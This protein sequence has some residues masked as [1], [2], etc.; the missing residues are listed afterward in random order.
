MFATLHNLV[1]TSD[2]PFKT[3][4]GISSKR[5]AELRR[6]TAYEQLRAYELSLSYETFFFFFFWSHNH[7][8]QEIWKKTPEISLPG[9]W[10]Q[11]ID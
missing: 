10:A 1:P 5:S 3:I 7:T 11:L 2:P 6:I 4:C 8:L 9:M